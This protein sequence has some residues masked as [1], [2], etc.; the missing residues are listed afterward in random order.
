VVVNGRYQLGVGGDF[1]TAIDGK[2]VT[3]NGALDRAM[4]GKRGG[5]TLELTI[6]RNGRSLTVKVHLGEAPQVI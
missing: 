4:S 2:P 1:I 5:D 3:A 6:I